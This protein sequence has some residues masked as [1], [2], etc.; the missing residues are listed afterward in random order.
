M[1]DIWVH[2]HPQSDPHYCRLTKVTPHF[3]TSLSVLYRVVETYHYWPLDGAIIK[4]IQQNKL[5]Q[6]YYSSYENKQLF[7]TIF[8]KQILFDR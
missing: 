8:K 7:T 4:F 3:I 5:Q 2:S 1:I 6:K